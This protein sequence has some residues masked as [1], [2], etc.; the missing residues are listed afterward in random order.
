MDVAE[1]LAVAFEIEN[2]PTFAVIKGG[3]E[4]E[5]VKVKKTGGTQGVVNAV[6]EAAIEASK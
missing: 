4:K 5:H 6:F 2:M 3:V 1:D